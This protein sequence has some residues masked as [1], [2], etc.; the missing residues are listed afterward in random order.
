MRREQ[1]PASTKVSR[2][3]A[4]SPSH[5]LL[6]GGRSGVGKTTVAVE[7]HRQLSESAVHHAWI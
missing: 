5:L 7:I 1:R 4:V 2:L 3:P 6:I